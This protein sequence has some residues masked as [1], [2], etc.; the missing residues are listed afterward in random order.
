MPRQDRYATSQPELSRARTALASQTTTS[1]LAATL[2]SGMIIV[3][4]MDFVTRVWGTLTALAAQIPLGDL[5][6]VLHCVWEIVV[7]DLDSTPALR[8]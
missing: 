6:V 5:L 1:V 7:S 3:F 2:P 4:L 8:E